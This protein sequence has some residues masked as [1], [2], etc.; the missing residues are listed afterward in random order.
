[1]P[2]EMAAIAFDGTYAAE[3]E[4][5]NLRVS[6][7]DPWLS[8]VAVLE[9]HHSGRY[10]MKA[11]SPDYGDRDHVGAGI[12]IGGGTGLLLGLIGGPLGLL[13]WG[14][15]GATLGGAAGAAKSSAEG[16]AFDPLV[17]EVKDALPDDT[18]ALTRAR[19][20]RVSHGKSFGPGRAHRILALFLPGFF[21]LAGQ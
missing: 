16:G 9:H 3:G 6:R 11:T 21:V 19:P 12:A 18:S 14:A 8:E 4:L 2:V 13:F 7:V 20:G 17:N 15:V 1:M 10:S 5:S